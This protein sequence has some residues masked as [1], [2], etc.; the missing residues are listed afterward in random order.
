MRSRRRHGFY[1]VDDI[2]A[3]SSAEILL[4]T[5]QQ[6]LFLPVKRRQRLNVVYG[7]QQRSRYS[8]YWG[9]RNG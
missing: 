7:V 2:T 9:R 4:L 8:A 5:L 3:L 1:F 6:T